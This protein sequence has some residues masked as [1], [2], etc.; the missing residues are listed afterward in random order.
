MQ[1]ASRAST[2][3]Q[4][5]FDQTQSR[6][7][8]L[9]LPP[10]A[11]AFS[12][13]LPNAPRPAAKQRPPVQRSRTT[14]NE[15]DF[16][17][18]AP[19]DTEGGKPKGPKRSGAGASRRKVIADKL[20][21]DIETGQPINYCFHCGAIETPTW[22]RIYIKECDGTPTGLDSHE[23]EGET[24]GVEVL[25]DKET[26]VPLNKFLVRKSMKRTKEN[27]IGEEFEPKQ[28]C[29]PCGLWFNK[30]RTMRPE[31][32]WNRKAS[33]RNR[34]KQKDG[35]DAGPATDGPE[36]YSEAP[37]FTDQVGPD[38]DSTEENE[39][40]I[41]PQLEGLIVD[42]RPAP[43]HKPRANSLQA[44][45]HRPPAPQRSNTMAR[46]IQS[47]PV[48]GFHGSQQSP[49]EIEDAT[50]KPTR[51]LLFP[52][53]RGAGQVKSLEDNRAVTVKAAVATG[54]EIETVEALVKTTVS[55]KPGLELAFD[56]ACH[57]N[58]FEAFTFDKENVSPNLDF[59]EDDLAHLFEG[60]P[61]MVFKTPRK[62]PSAKNLTTPRSKKQLSHLLRTPTPASRKC[63]PLTPNA[64]AGNAGLATVTQQP[65]NDFMT[66]P[67]SSR[68][69]LRSTPSR[70][71]RT[72]G[73]HSSSDDQRDISPW[74][75]HLAQML[76][77]VNDGNG[78]TSVAMGLTS[79]SSR[80]FGD[81]PDM[82]TFMTPGRVGL[83]DCGWEGLEGLL[84]NYDASP[85]D[86]VDGDVGEGKEG[87]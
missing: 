80:A 26:G 34:K 18:P 7:G 37:F 5:P 30:F 35:G 55:L 81:F 32:K 87:E 21:K 72:P 83:E 82:P 8:S 66:S 17:S 42:Q 68:Y 33:T 79:P 25:K 62:T 51:R 76:S 58:I 44:Q 64:N 46:E 39:M 2:V 84:G 24:I 56:S 13:D 49:I 20:M 27:P 61:N 6:R 73:R 22:R 43:S 28:V 53:P 65:I 59:N 63:I 15:S 86:A 75:R 40:P 3:A 38:D 14:F 47:S 1:P 16:G 36:P 60:S 70:L 29:N 23:G 52:S 31:E 54:A 11:P 9:A 77:D 57:S 50:P 71:E 78:G 4:T 10:A 69:F 85:S 67:S 12:S 74:S 45:Q 19:S 48:R 41:D